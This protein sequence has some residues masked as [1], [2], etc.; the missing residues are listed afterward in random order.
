MILYI[1]NKTTGCGTDVMGI[2][3]TKEKALEK[4]QLLIDNDWCQYRPSSEEKDVWVAVNYDDI[5]ISF[6][7]TVLDKDC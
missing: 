3:S 2:Y 6:Y 5:W 7:E 1:V 4:I